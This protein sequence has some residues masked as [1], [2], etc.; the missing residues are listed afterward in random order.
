MYTEAMA[1]Q[2]F[3]RGFKDLQDDRA[4]E[5]SDDGLRWWL[6]SEDHDSPRYRAATLDST[7]VR[8]KM[9]A[10]DRGWQSLYLEHLY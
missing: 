7:D 9:R 2:D 8:K 5:L 1:E 6:D 10:I 4:R 3:T